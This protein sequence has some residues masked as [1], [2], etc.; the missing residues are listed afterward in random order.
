MRFNLR[1][2]L[3]CMTIAA[4]L[5]GLVHRPM[6]SV[7]N[8]MHFGLVRA[9]ID[10]FRTT[11]WLLHID[12]PNYYGSILI[13]QVELDDPT[14]AVYTNP[15][16]CMWYLGVAACAIV[17]IFAVIWIW[18]VF[19]VLWTWSTSENESLS[20]VWVRMLRESYD[21]PVKNRSNRHADH[22]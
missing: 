22:Y 13:G 9:F 15:E 1:M 21:K 19:G 5:L 2:L 6:E 17:W 4:V 7:T 16:I 10:P 12:I 18:F 8:S 14:K 20:A 3:T 11:L